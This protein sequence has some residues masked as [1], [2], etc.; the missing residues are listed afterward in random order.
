MKTAFARALA[1]QRDLDV[2]HAALMRSASPLRESL[3]R[4]PA[5]W[6]VGGGFVAGLVAGFVPLHRLLQTGLSFAT[7]SMRLLTPFLAG[8]EV[9]EANSAT[10]AESQSS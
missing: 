4:R 8:I 10:T 3:R 9:H 5:T 1:A 2:A 7:T 6:L